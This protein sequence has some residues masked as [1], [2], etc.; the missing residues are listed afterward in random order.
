MNNLDKKRQNIIKGLSLSR[1]KLIKF[2][3][4]KNSPIAISK[5]GKIVTVNVE[6]LPPS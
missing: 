6:D 5:N 1:K 2:K 4:E 3:K